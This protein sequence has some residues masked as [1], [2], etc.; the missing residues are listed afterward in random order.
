MLGF[1]CLGVPWLIFGGL[2]VGLGFSAKRQI[3][4]SLGAETGE[5]LATAAQVIGFIDLV[6]A[7]LGILA[8]VL[9]LVIGMAAGGGG[10]IR[11]PTCS[12]C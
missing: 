6:L 9:V 4:A 1:L 7:L 11:Q 3:R 5:S 12:G 8:L 10:I 2:G